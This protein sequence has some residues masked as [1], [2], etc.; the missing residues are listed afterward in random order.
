MKLTDNEKH[1]ILKLIEAEKPLPDNLSS[2][3]IVTM[4]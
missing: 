3:E 2:R 1:E 4:K